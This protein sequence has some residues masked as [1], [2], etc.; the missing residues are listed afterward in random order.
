M[1]SMS[2]VR[3]VKWGKYCKRTRGQIMNIHMT[4][5]S[6]SAISDER[7]VC[8]K[9]PCFAA[10]NRKLWS[11]A[12]RFEITSVRKRFI[13]LN[14]LAILI[15]VIRCKFIAWRYGQSVRMIFWPRHI[16]LSF[17]VGAGIF[18]FC[19]CKD[20]PV[21]ILVPSSIKL[22]STLMCAP[23]ACNLQRIKESSK[24]I[25]FW[26]KFP[27]WNFA[28]NLNGLLYTTGFLFTEGPYHYMAL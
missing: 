19:G 9:R 2:V 16:E 17:V 22:W 28:W 5:H 18:F 10:C 23:H 14:F 8:W 7:S 6:T 1:L 25:L 15:Q 26:Y 20:N 3:I 27:V 12:R 24:Y 21:F 13:Y 11:S 4:F